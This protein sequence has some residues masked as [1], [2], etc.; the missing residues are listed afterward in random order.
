MLT[1][2][3]LMNYD[4]PAVSD[5]PFFACSGFFVAGGLTGLG[6]AFRIG[7]AATISSFQYTQMVWAVI[8]G[9]LIF[10]DLPDLLTWVGAAIIITSGLYL[11]HAEHN[12]NKKL[13][14]KETP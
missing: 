2:F 10:G 8:L 9:Y 6:I 3:V 7:K 4:L 11:I 12:A 5:W 13:A 14:K 1:P